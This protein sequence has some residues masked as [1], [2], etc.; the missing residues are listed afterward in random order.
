MEAD[1]D[2]GDGIASIDVTGAI[3]WQLLGFLSV[4]NY[5]QW[6]AVGG[7]WLGFVNNVKPVLLYIHISNDAN[8]MLIL[9]MY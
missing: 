9:Y 6:Q 7:N 8:E 5:T 2:V 4:S 3:K 1:G